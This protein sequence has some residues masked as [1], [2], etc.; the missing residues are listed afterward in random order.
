ML[1]VPLLCTD[2]HS[3]DPLAAYQEALRCV[4]TAWADRLAGRLDGRPS[5]SRR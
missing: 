5:A 2:V 1:Q 4:G 3:G